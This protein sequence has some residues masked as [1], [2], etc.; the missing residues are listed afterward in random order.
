MNDW[1]ALSRPERCARGV[2]LPLP[3]RAATMVGH[4]SSCSA[5][6]NWLSPL[7]S[8]LSAS[9]SHNGMLQEYPPLSE[10]QLT[11][12]ATVGAILTSDIVD[13]ERIAQWSGSPVAW[14]RVASRARHTNILR[15]VMLGFSTLNGCGSRDPSSTCDPA[16]CW[17]RRMLDALTAHLQNTPQYAQVRIEVK[18]HARSAQHPTYFQHCTAESFIPHATDLV[19]FE[20]GANMYDGKTHL[21]RLLPAFR[22][23]AP[24]AAV[25]LIFWARAL[26]SGVGRS[27]ELKLETLVRRDAKAL[28]AD[29]IFV[30]E[31]LAQLSNHSGACGTPAY[32]IGTWVARDGHDHH[33]SGHGHHLMGEIVAHHLHRRLVASLA[34]AEHRAARTSESASPHSGAPP[35]MEEEICINT[36]ARL[37]VANAS[38]DWTLV[39]EG[40]KGV[41][42][43][44]WVSRRVGDSLDL[45]VTP[46]PRVA[47]TAVCA[48]VRL[49]YLLSTHRGL[50][51]MKLSCQGTCKCHGGLGGGL[52]W[53]V[54]ADCRGSGNLDCPADRNITV[55]DIEQ[56]ELTHRP[57]NAS[58]CVL[59]V[60]H[61]ASPFN[62]AEAKRTGVAL[63]SLPSKVRIDSLGWTNAKPYYRCSKRVAER[64]TTPAAPH[65]RTSTRTRRAPARYR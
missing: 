9:F 22:G 64:A 8:P 30:S 10:P 61:I 33:P 43:W 21:E 56:F 63:A 1:G 49:G 35:S 14:Q 24:P 3:E 37:P 54:N 34:N 47:S 59:R 28:E 25:V 42:K 19:I 31:G 13:Q 36:A 48:T 23:A 16:L 32:R 26:S 39:D 17:S 51:Q 38:G 4:R 7:R 58:S 55:T 6:A 50:G 11:L 65:N 2:A 41:H 40:G 29:A 15:V 44:G 53:R 60:T 20:A 45:T 27:I 12:P 52:E 62:V 57:S 5:V 18:A 46:P